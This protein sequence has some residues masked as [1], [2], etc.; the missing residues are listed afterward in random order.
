M[1]SSGFIRLLVR[2]R[3]CI[4]LWIWIRWRRSL[5]YQN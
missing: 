3:W 2:W 1:D 4:F 5:H